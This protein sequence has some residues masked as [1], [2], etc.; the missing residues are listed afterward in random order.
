MALIDSLPPIIRNNKEVEQLHDLL[1]FQLDLD[2][3]SNIEGLKSQVEL[4]PDDLDAKRQ[5]TIQYVI[6]N[7]HE[8]ALEQLVNI[9]EIDPGY[10][11]N[12]AR[13]A[14][15]KLF[16]ILGSEHALVRKYRPNLKRYAH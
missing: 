3:S 5:L 13:S 14:M 15:L 7:Q 4:S 9:M 16:N 6:D 2:N 8:K 10:Q 12:Y 1:T 11:D